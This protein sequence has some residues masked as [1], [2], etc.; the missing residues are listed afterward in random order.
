MIC[1]QYISMNLATMLQ[2]TTMRPM[3]VCDISFPD[4]EYRLPT[5]TTLNDM[6]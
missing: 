5:I 1:H 3:Q 2:G 6:G 4:I